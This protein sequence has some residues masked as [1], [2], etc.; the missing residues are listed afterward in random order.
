[1]SGLADD[2]LDLDAIIVEEGPA[3]TDSVVD[4]TAEE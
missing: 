1:M 4:V 3:V 2:N